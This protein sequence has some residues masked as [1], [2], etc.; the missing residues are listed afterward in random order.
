MPGFSADDFTD[1]FKKHAE[2]KKAKEEF[3]DP[4]PADYVEPEVKEEE[5]PEDK[6]DDDW[7]GDPE[8]L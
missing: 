2:V 7:V 3:V 4:R 1:N 8:W 6:T 5:D